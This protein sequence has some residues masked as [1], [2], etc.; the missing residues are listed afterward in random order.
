MK[1]IILCAALA[2]SALAEGQTNPTITMTNTGTLKAGQPTTVTASINTPAGGTAPSI[3]EFAL[4]GNPALGPVTPTTALANKTLYCAA[5]LHPEFC[6]LAGMNK[7]PLAN[8]TIASFNALLSSTATGTE[9]LTLAGLVAVDPSGSA[10]PI[11]SP[12]LALLIPNQCDLNADGTVDN[13]DFA[14][15]ATAIAV[16][17]AA[18][19]YGQTPPSIPPGFDL[20]KDGV[21]NLKDLKILLDNA[22]GGAC[23]A[24]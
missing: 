2:L 8:G 12:N 10:L 16:Q 18:R 15:I 9:V 19:F 17:E 6:V 23:L 3:V 22:L 24:L 21:L 5:P 4:T 14:Q 20:N 11:T 7:T 1:H 13:L